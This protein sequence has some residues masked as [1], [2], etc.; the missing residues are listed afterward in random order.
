MKDKNVGSG[1]KHE[2]C[3]MLFNRK[4]SEPPEILRGHDSRL[5]KKTFALEI[6]ISCVCVWEPIIYATKESGMSIRKEIRTPTESIWI[7]TNKQHRHI[8][9]LLLLLESIKKIMKVPS[10]GE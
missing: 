6:Y 3:K 2:Q 9:I 8:Y 1:I 5:K 4:F 7:L 10:S